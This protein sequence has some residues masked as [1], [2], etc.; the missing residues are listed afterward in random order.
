MPDQPILLLADDGLMFP[1]RIGEAARPLGYVLRVA[2]SPGKVRE[3]AGETP[4]VILINLNARRFD[5]NALI[6]SLKADAATRDLPILAFAGHVERD[7]HA[8]ARAAGADMTAANSSISL[9]L[10]KLLA[11][12]LSGERS[13]DAPEDDEDDPQEPS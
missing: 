3:A 9:H 6:Q 1:S 7:R 11:R 2:A 5:P 10:P 13:D 8:A 4:A 12:L